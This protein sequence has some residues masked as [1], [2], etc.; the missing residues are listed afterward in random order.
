MQLYT[1]T[2]RDYIELLHLYVDADCLC[3]GSTLTQE[4]HTMITH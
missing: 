3:A 2:K 4:A 1:D